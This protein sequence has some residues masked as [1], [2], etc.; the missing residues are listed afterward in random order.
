MQQCAIGNR[1]FAKLLCGTNAVYAR[2]HFSAAKDAEYQAR[3]TDDG[4][5]ALL[6]RCAA[7]GIDTLETSANERIWNLLDRLRSAEQIHFKTIGSTRIDGTSDIKSP[8]RKLRFLL[9]RKADICVIHAQLADSPRKGEIAGLR[10][11]VDQ[12]HA[13]GLL[14]A[15]ST[16]RVE[17]VLHCEACGY[18]L[19]TYL[20]PLN[21]A[22]FVYPGY[23]GHE[24]V[25]E[26]AAVVRQVNKPFILMKVL[27][28]G[29]L[30]PD[31]GL[32]FIAEH[33]KPTDLITI[34]FGS[35]AEAEECVAIAGRLWPDME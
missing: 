5:C 24:T 4:I 23:D 15:I 20:F 17:T 22:G 9:E 21:L 14:A 33:A 11:R 3:F 1:T 10:K 30:P 26:R 16:H 12:I 25:A 19:D 2:S 32:S 27:A 13:A 8:E 18:G 31:E 28:A 35:I 6:R 7:L 29:R 34:G